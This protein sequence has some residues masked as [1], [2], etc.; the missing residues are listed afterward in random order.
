[1]LEWHRLLHSGTTAEHGAVAGMIARA[2]LVGIGGQRVA[3][4]GEHRRFCGGT[5]P[6][7]TRMVLMAVVATAVLLAIRCCLTAVAVT[8]GMV[9]AVGH[10]IGCIRG[11]IQIIIG[12]TNLINSNIDDNANRWSTH[13][14]PRVRIPI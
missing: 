12:Q 6:R 4:L 13:E 11:R 10:R 7:H 9:L 8:V 5:F 14:E 2:A 1:M 3:V